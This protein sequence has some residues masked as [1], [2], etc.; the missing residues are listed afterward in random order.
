MRADLTDITLVV[1]RSGSMNLI[2]E[3]AEGGVNA[4]IADQAQQPGEALLTLVQFDTEYEFIHRGVPIQD[5]PPYAL[6]P[7]GS[8]ALLDAVGR[9][10]NETGQRLAGMN[11]AD[12]PGLVVFVVMTDGQE[13]SSRE[14]SKER[15]KQMIE[16]QQ[17]AYNWQFTFLGADQ[18]AFDDAAAI[19]I[20]AAGAACYAPDKVAMAYFATSDKLARMRRQRSAG[21]EV[22]NDFTPEERQRMS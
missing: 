19:G 1:D 21:Q 15:I 12:R 9:A 16:H 3:D 8:T 11:E 7:R 18:N 2:R 20:Q 6:H 10:I 14:F 13:N 4:F 22:Q 17:Q 5:V